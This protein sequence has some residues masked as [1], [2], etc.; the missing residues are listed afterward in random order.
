MKHIKL[1]L[2]LVILFGA[3]PVLAVTMPSP[4]SNVSELVTEYGKTGKV[5]SIDPD[6]KWIGINNKKYILNGTGSIKPEDLR[7]GLRVHYNIEK[8]KDE[9]NG[10]VTRMWV[11]DSAD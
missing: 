11:N 10:R 9:R 3:Q 1:F 2:S 8:A 6:G 5:D 4:G 7:P